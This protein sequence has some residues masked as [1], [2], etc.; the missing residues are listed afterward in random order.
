MLPVG[1]KTVL[2]NQVLHNPAALQSIEG[3]RES[4]GE[5]KESNARNSKLNTFCKDEFKVALDGN[6]Y[7]NSKQSQS[8]LLA[9]ADKE[10]TPPVNNRLR[11]L[12][13]LKQ[14]FRPPFVPSLR[15]NMKAEGKTL[16]LSPRKARKQSLR[17]RLKKAEERQVCN[18]KRF[19]D[20][21]ERMDRMAVENNKAIKLRSTPDPSPTENSE[22]SSEQRK[23]ELKNYNV[24]LLLYKS[25]LRRNH[26]TV[27]GRKEGKRESSK[28]IEYEGKSIEVAL[29]DIAGKFS[30]KL[31]V[32]LL[33][34]EVGCKSSDEIASELYKLEQA[35]RELEK[36][37]R[38]KERKENAN[39]AIYHLNSKHQSLY[40]HIELLKTI[41]KPQPKPNTL[42]K[43]P[44]TTAK[45]VV[46]Y[47]YLTEVPLEETSEPK[48]C[49]ENVEDNGVE[50]CESDEYESVSPI[51]SE[52]EKSIEVGKKVV[53]VNGEVVKKSLEN[54]KVYAGTE[55]LPIFL[56]KKFE[57]KGAVVKEQHECIEKIILGKWGIGPKVK[58]YKSADSYY[59]ITYGK[60]CLV[61]KCCDSLVLLTIS[62]DGVCKLACMNKACFLK[63]LELLLLPIE[64]KKV[65]FPEAK[66][67]INR[68]GIKNISFTH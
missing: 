60:S 53:R 10:K 41:R 30:K 15:P 39:G 34:K 66:G 58:A 2:T 47:M 26:R 67:G 50:Y 7:Y 40:R 44:A 62:C 29:P 25:Y 65:L 51:S 48:V 18:C 56:L 27:K 37:K 43:L 3:R 8:F 22:D 45:P 63:T 24:K 46:P 13:H 49:D 57:L 20:R 32:S 23:S 54:S 1:Q 19:V 59:A 4:L 68:A 5:A 14:S 11:N 55:N 61:S 42:F 31:D 12:V 16:T 38:I 9:C 17:V 35:A 21:W 52:A 6:L 28:T 36:I 64:H 33:G